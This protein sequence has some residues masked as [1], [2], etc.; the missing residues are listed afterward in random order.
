MWMF[1]MVSNPILER[2][3]ILLFRSHQRWGAVDNPVFPSHTKP[4]PCYC[5]WVGH[6]WAFC[7]FCQV[8]LRLSHSPDLKRKG[9][10]HKMNCP[11]LNIYE[12]ITLRP[13]K[14]TLC[15]QMR[16]STIMWDP[17]MI[18][19]KHTDQTLQIWFMMLSS[20]MALTLSWTIISSTPKKQVTN[21][22][23]HMR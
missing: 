10:E 22:L 11:K 18:S 8:R 9:N 6:S 2:D 4:I 5:W 21:T 7:P 13:L 20:G 14:R 12:G 23:Q 17:G 19:M 1:S 16:S 3:I 15:W